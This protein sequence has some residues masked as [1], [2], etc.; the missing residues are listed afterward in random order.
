MNWKERLRNLRYEH[1]KK[2]YPQAYKDGHLEHVLRHP[3]KDTNANALTA[4]IVDYINFSG[5][6][7]TRINTTGTIRKIKGEMKWTNGGTRKGTADIHAIVAGTHVSIEVKFG[8]DR[9]S[10]NQVKERERIEQAG[11]IYY[12]ATG[13][14]NFVAWYD[15]TFAN[16]KITI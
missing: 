7:A 11:G 10:K 1:H 4:C 14:E 3:Y 5:G 15:E 12:V 16:P 2:Q 6:S 9:L 13:M 8:K